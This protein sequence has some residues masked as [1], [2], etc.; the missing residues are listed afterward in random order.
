MNNSYRLSSSAFDREKED[1]K[2][3]PLKIYFLS[4]EGNVT[5]K[6]YFEGIAAYREELHIN[7]QVRMEVLSRSN[8]D[9][10]SAPKQ[11]IE[12]LEDY[13]RL[14]EMGEYDFYKDIPME[15]VDEYGEESV[16]K[17][18]EDPNLLSKEDKDKIEESLRILGYDYA[19]RRY[20]HECGGRESDVFA[21]IIDRDRKSHTEKGL[22]EC[23]SH[24]RKNNYSCYISNPCFEFWLLL[25]ACDVKEEY[26]DKLEEIRK[27]EKVSRTHTFVSRELS[28]R[29]H[30]K[31]SGIAFKQK[32]LPHVDEAIARAKKFESD[33]ERLLDN[34]G[35]NIWKLLE[36]MRDFS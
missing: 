21:I 10:N 6:E 28:N 4:V 31:K 14:R 25:H 19:Y 8:E 23:I 30:H 24:C 9:T 27:N 12:L 1:E 22:K 20:L 2:I 13:L 7:G 17:Y 15:V 3:E 34:I 26:K 33:E 16:K 35:T 32:Y 18:I 36:S 11:V 5:E 29:N